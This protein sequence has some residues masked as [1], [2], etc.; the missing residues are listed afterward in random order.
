MSRIFLSHSSRDT[1]QAIALKQ[2]LIEQTPPLANEI[3]LDVDPG[4]G[5]RAGTRWKDALRQAN[6][7]CEAVICLL[8]KNWE[9]SHECKVEYRT[10]ENLNKQIFVARLE[11][12]T[13][14]DL[15]S[16]WQRCDLFGEGPTTAIDTGQGDPVEFATAGLYRLRD[17][18]RGA[19][20]GA[21]S[22]V[23]PPPRD[24]DRAPYRGWEPL[25]EADAAVFFGRDAQIVRALDTVRGMRLS[26]VTSMFVVLGPSGTGKS[27]FLRA[28]LLPRLRRED[29]RF[30]VMNI[31][32]P[33]RNVLSGDAGFAAALCATRSEFG[34]SEPSL[35]EVKAACLAGDADR[36]ISMLAE[37]RQ[38]AADRLLQRGGD[39]DE[40]VAP[41]V[42][43]PLDQAE[44]LFNAEHAESSERFLDLLRQILDAANG[45]DLGLAVAATIRTDRFEIMQTHPRLAGLG[46]ALFD[47]LKP[48]PATQFKEV[49]VGPA[50]RST[51][52]GRPLQI[53]VDL[54]DRLLADAGSGA[55]TLPML[56]LTL[57]RLYTDYG[58]TGELTLRQYEG[59]GGMNRV[60]Q[61]EI[62][63]VLSRDAV[64]RTRQLQALRSAFIPWL[65]T[66]NPD[67]GQPMR[68]VARLSDLPQ[69]S[70]GLI[71]ALVAK[72]LMV[73]DVRG[74]TT[75]V[76]VALESL[77]R[78]WSELA[79]WLRDERK[80]LRDADD[81]IRGAAAWRGSNR[82]PAWLLE[83][84]RLSEAAAL[85]NRPGFRERLREVHD[86]LDASHRRQQQER[87]D[88]EKRRRGELIAAQEREQAAQERARYA[89]E[90]QLT[91]ERHATTLRKRGRVLRSVL[92]LTAVVA[93][94]A[95]AGL[96]WAVSANSRAAERFRQ[97]TSLRL[98]SD[99][100][101][102]MRGTRPGGDIQAI[103]QMVAARA[104]TSSPDDY[105]LSTIVEQDN[106]TTKIIPAQG[107]MAGVSY[108]PDGSRL[109]ASGADGYVRVW[110]A[111]SG[112]PVVDPIPDH[113]G[114]SEIA[115]SPDG[116][117]LVTADRD[118]V[119]RIFD[120]GDFSVDH[121]IDTGTE[122]LS[123]IAFTSDGSRFATIGNDRVI[124][125]VDT[126]T[127]D[128]VREF[129]S[130]HQGY[131]S[132]LAFSP[133]G[134]LLL[135]G[136]EDGTLQM[137]D[138][139]AGTA[140]GPRIETGGMVADVAFRPDGRRFVS[141]GNSVILWDTQ[142]R[143]P[144]GDPLQGHVNA[145]TTVSFSP[146]SQVLA[147][148]SADATVR[149]W[150]ADTGAFLW[151]VM[152]GH[153]GRIWGLVYSP[154]GRHIASASSDGTVRI[155][156]PLG[157]QPL[158]GHTAAVRDLSYSPD[159]EFMASAG[160]DGTVRLWDPDTH[161]L[162]GRPLDAGVPLYALDFSEDSSTLVAGGDGGTVVLW[163]MGSRQVAGRYETGRAGAIRTLEFE[164]KGERLSV[165][166]WD[167]VASVMDIDGQ[168]VGEEV[169]D[170]E[171][172]TL[173]PAW[174]LAAT[175]RM[176][177]NNVYVLPIGGDSQG[178]EVTLEGHTN[179]VGR[180]VF[181]PD[182]SLLVSASDDTTVRRWNPATGESVG[183]P[184]A[185][186]TDEVLDLAFSPDG[187]RLVTGSADTTARLWDVA[188][189]RQIADP[190][191]GHT[192]HVT[193]VA[194]DPDGG[195]FATGSRD[196]TVRVRSV[197]ASP[198][199]LC[200][201]LTANM[202]H[203]QW[204]VWV[205][206]DI[207]YVQACPGLPIAP[208]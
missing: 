111:E 172:I 26:G 9:A 109:A 174:N 130:G 73:S 52:G 104:L 189:G 29:R 67:N 196:G 154:D 18:I 198:E 63:E 128:P 105:A 34:L 207:D 106:N 188:T 77:L 87:D 168:Q 71:D 199:M 102:M 53:A 114:V 124:Q 17:G 192:E 22:F 35:G 51:E 193:S 115:F 43:L 161:Q 2:W 107:V 92:A 85:V 84:T 36:V 148:G 119:L 32:R 97:A 113:Q 93:V 138:A 132:E 155:W 25:D 163:N 201:K 14:D 200:A 204:D 90:Q 56:A 136:S 79:G 135:S 137:W 1:R 206:P 142:T 139:E 112:Q 49:I 38:V 127:G 151:N 3:F 60:V 141:S 175:S 191:V 8:S 81:L 173:S 171:A 169:P 94:V 176:S 159:G 20:I 181:N 156:N 50:Q 202:S 28:G 186:H 58:S 183:G 72:R 78:Q 59:M 24:P 100:L 121:E 12:S 4:S 205:S 44:E 46:T 134:A 203:K 54:V 131:V 185:G 152:Y 110:D 61:S 182:G 190:Y 41:T 23:W 88:E 184:L 133:D 96:A 69:D 120:A 157:S 19:G 162:L 158:L 55:D 164:D 166:D 179:R 15:T 126:D 167:G 197:T 194:F 11:P 89:Q 27:S 13:G 31:V 30:V 47:D 147:T 83:G 66:I 10:A 70:R 37:L 177:E 65:A 178:S 86:Y 91:A 150:D 45:S 40:L 108:S 122:N 68:R 98:T 116:Q 21:A 57:A 170:V 195:S 80:D 153:E 143:K 180:L 48:M 101:A 39:G 7:R 140:I 103:Q 125:V 145:V 165:L 64:R 99:S 118:G 117:A 76:E 42:I 82:N 149:V 75:V 208:D 5:L 62:D 6:A 33:E 129:P 16:E 95:V 187:T 74:G 146:D 160:E 144:I 123:S